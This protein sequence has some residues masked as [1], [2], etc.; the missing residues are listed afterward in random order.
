MSQEFYLTLPSN[1]SLDEF[2]N[3]SN[4][5]FKVRLPKPMRLEGGGWKVALSNLSIPDPKNKLPDWLDNDTPLIY[6]SWYHHVRGDTSKRRFLE[7]SFLLRDIDAHVDVEMMSGH[8]FMRSLV[9][10]LEKKQLENNLEPDWMIASAS[11]HYHI[12]FVV[13]DNEVLFDCSKVALHNFGRENRELSQPFSYMSP[14]I[15]IH[16]R[17]AVDMGWFVEDPSESDPQFAYKLGPNLKAELHYAER[18]IPFS[19]DIRTNWG[20]QSQQVSQL[21]HSK[22]W[23]VPRK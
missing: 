18:G 10:Y 3:N 14:S 11:D 23:M 7:A 9:N 15:F 20:P 19:K 12:D 13:S 8:D 4:S 16:K 1:S 6:T 17:L 22:Y 5:S 2:P 21:H